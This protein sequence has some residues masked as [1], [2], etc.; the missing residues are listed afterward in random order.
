MTSPMVTSTAM[1]KLAVT[2]CAAI[3]A[4]A[5]AFTEPFTWGANAITAIPVGI[6]AVVL[7]RR[8]QAGRQLDLVT[9]VK[10]ARP[11]RSR[12]AM[13]WL[14]LAV[15]VGGWELFCYFSTPRS[16][17][18]TLSILI[19]MATASHGGRGLA[20]FLWLALGFVMVAP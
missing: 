11:L 7:V 10:K 3:L 13:T 17:H 8:L 2:L 6:A 14:G 5:A 16:A 18:P 12:W 15:A 9:P 19:N 4:V 20:F 1:N